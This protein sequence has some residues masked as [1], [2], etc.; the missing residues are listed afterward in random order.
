ML[1]AFQGVTLYAQQDEQSSL[2]MFNPLYFNPAYA[3]SRNSI[4]AVGIGRFQ[5]VGMEG[6]PITQFAS[7][8]M[9][10]RSQSIGLGVHF[11]HDRIG[12]RERTGVYADFS[13]SI[14]LNKKGH[15]LAF[16][17]NAG[18][19]FANYNFAT[20]PTN[21]PNDP[22]LQNSYSGI[23]PNI[24][25]GIYYYGDRFFAGASIPRIL[26]DAVLESIDQ[27][28]VTKRHIFITGGY[29]FRLN[30]VLDLKTS[31]LV[32]LTPFAPVT[33][34]VNASLYIQKRF[35]I[36]AM[37]RYHESVGANLAINIAPWMTVG[38]AFDYPINDLRTNQFGT[39]EVMLSFD[40]TAGRKSFISPRYF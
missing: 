13:F 8:D 37:Y 3:G 10:V 20:V 14:R 32:K 15:R 25:G 23:R 21:N 40:F 16:G 4:H 17:V 39:H 18:A 31:A 11:V 30:S 12:A 26:D 22:I 28:S 38:Y 6:A 7:F 1:V 35:W 36:G 5:W 24:G 33:F 19:D 2:Y 9:P 29:V 34:D 27:V